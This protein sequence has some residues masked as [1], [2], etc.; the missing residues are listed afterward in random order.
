MLNSR[1]A[2]SIPEAADSAG[3]SRSRF[4]E[5]LSAGDGPP[6]VKLGRRRL[7]RRA[8][9][10]SWLAGLEGRDELAEPGGEAA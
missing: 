8:A 6:T 1:V 5:L 9:L 4:Y 10:E 2:L 3:I 7:V